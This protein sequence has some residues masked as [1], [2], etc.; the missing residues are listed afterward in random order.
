MFRARALSGVPEKGWRIY[1]RR[2][3][4]NVLVVRPYHVRADGW[5][6]SRAQHC[7]AQDSIA[8]KAC[9]RSV[10]DVDFQFITSYRYA[11][12]AACPCMASKSTSR[13][14]ARYAQVPSIPISQGPEPPRPN[15]FSQ[16]PRSQKRRRHACNN[17]RR[18][19]LPQQNK[20]SIFGPSF[21]FQIPPPRQPPQS[22]RAD[23]SASP[24]HHQSPSHPAAHSARSSCPSRP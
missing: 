15:Q 7:T 11:K 2:R 18:P 13:R 14:C 4:R 17:K 8:R 3:P 1:A 24:P 5:L 22:Q 16:N 6:H 10:V 9:M 20:A 23:Y 19:N 21:T 12:N